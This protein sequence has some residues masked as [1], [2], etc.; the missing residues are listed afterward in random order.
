[1]KG[2]RLW[3][4]TALW[5][6]GYTPL[7]LTSDRL[8]PKT[9]EE[10]GSAAAPAVPGEETPRAA[11]RHRALPEALASRAVRLDDTAA[12]TLEGIVAR[13]SDVLRADVV[14]EAREAGAE[15][16]PAPP[17]PLAPL[18]V[19]GARTVGEL[20]DAIAPRSEYGW[21]CEEGAGLEPGR[22]IF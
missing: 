21:E 16:R 6:A 4:I 2:H 19:A 3:I 11:R 22:L 15:G 5:A 12:M 13:L 7:A 10:R 18:P 14:F 9:V 17:D 8:A 1:M 20:L